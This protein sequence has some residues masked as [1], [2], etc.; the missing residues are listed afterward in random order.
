[1][2]AGLFGLFFD[3][4]LT[5][6]WCVAPFVPNCEAG[7]VCMNVTFRWQTKTDKMSWESTIMSCS[8]PTRL[9]DFTVDADRLT[10]S[11][12]FWENMFFFWIKFNNLLF[13]IA[14]YFW[15]QT[16]SIQ[17]AYRFLCILPPSETSMVG[18]PFI[19]ISIFVGGRSGRNFLTNCWHP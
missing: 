6:D 8:D 1:M 9:K 3:A 4:V 5:F 14:S 10:Q 12:M 15:L 19:L 18:I 7:V 2:H 13:K 11:D 16:N 17:K